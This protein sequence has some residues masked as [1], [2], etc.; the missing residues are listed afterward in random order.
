MNTDSKISDL[1]PAAKLVA[2][3]AVVAASVSVFFVWGIRMLMGPDSYYASWTMCTYLAT[4]IVIVPSWVVINSR[5]WVPLLVILDVVSLI[6]LGIVLFS[7]LET[8]SFNMSMLMNITCAFD[9]VFHFVFSLFS[10]LGK[11]K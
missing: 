10:I 6:V 8:M 4:V 7:T 1:S 2:V 11:V 5:V 3:I 9:V